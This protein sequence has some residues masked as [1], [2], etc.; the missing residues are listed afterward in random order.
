MKAPANGSS[1]TTSTQIPAE[2][3]LLL[4][5]YGSGIPAERRL[6]E[7]ASL[8]RAAGGVVV[9]AIVQRRPSNVGEDRP[10]APATY[11]G[12]GKVQEVAHAVEE[13]V[14]QAVV[15]DNELSPAQIR[16]LE[17]QFGCRVL[18][19]SE[20]ILDIFASRA[21]TRAAKLQVELAQLQYTAPRL[22]GMWSHL[23]R[24]AGQSGG[25]GIATRGPGEQQLEIDRRLVQ[26]RILLLQERLGQI[27]ARKERQVQARS[28]RAWGVGLVGY[29]NAGKSTLLNALTR[30]EAYAADQLFATL[31]T[32]SR[33]WEVQPGL[34]IPLSDTV[35]FV[36]DLP[37]HLVTG[38]RSTLAEAL[39]ASLLLHVVDAS[40]P[41]AEEQVKV[42]QEVLGELGVPPHRVLGVLNKC[43]QVEDP[44]VLAALAQLLPDAVRVSAITGEGLE[45]LCDRVA[46][47]RSQDWAELAVRVPMDQGALVAKV[48]ERG[49]VVQQRWEEDGWHA[50]IRV[51]RGMLHEV[52]PFESPADDPFFAADT[53]ES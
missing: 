17:G 7:L 4:G 37:H 25:G 24:Q 6:A 31:D 35:G 33:R 13:H 52:V 44:L 12:S 45:T 36:R 41:D 39:H 5:V 9:H 14:V 40:H 46:A 50:T 34:A 22:R 18:D 21:R 47:R 15:F 29:T 48:N 51:P 23:A 16:E 32:V 8:V 1:R 38:F 10:I 20:V 30:A 49:E 28:S 53:P 43:D 42:V 2:R 11:I 27:E 3:V 19:R 26:K